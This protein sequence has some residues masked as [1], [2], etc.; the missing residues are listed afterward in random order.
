VGATDTASNPISAVILA[1]GHSTR[2][3]CDKAFIEV[4]GRPL[5]ER[6][7]ETV[8]QLSTEVI[9]V[10]NALEVYEQFEALVLSDVYPGKGALGG[11]LSGLRAA[12]HQQALVVAC[13]MPFL[14][15]SLLRYM[16][17]LTS[18]MDVV[19]PRVGRLTEPLHAIY[20]RNCVPH[21]ERQ[22]VKGDLRIS[23]LLSEVRVRYVQASEI[24][25]FDPDHL[26]F[27]NINS[28]EDLARAKQIWARQQMSA[29]GTGASRRSSGLPPSHRSGYDSDEAGAA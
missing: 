19:I 23:H 17:G 12:S 8:G 13:D 29:L 5:I 3:G 28:P 7:V 27:F 9:I 21:I 11:I 10:A 2:L 14:N 16:Y 26:S 25:R 1:G 24:D 20:S 6:I 15:L 4:N 18:G 22:L